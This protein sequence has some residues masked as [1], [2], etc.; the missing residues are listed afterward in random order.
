MRYGGV[1]RDPILGL[2]VE[3]FQFKKPGFPAGS[4]LILLVGVHLLVEGA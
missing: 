4:D 1:I 3:L 2:A